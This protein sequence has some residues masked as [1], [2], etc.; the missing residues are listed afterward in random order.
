MRSTGLADVGVP[1]GRKL[2]SSVCITPLFQSHKNHLGYSAMLSKLSYQSMS[3]IL[4]GLVCISVDLAASESDTITYE[5][6]FFAPYNPVTAL[7]IVDRVPGFKLKRQG[8]SG[9]GGEE[10]V[11]GFGNNLSDVLINGKRP[12]TKSTP[13]EKILARY[14]AE[15]V[16]KVDLIRGATGSLESSKASVVVNLTMDMQQGKGSIP[17]QA[18]LSIEEGNI[19]PNGNA[20]YVGSRN[21][22]NYSIGIEREKYRFEFG[23]PE[24]LNSLIGPDEYRDE[25]LYEIPDKW[26][27]SADMERQI[28]SRDSFR[29]NTQVTDNNYEQG[30]DS[31]R[32]PEGQSRADLEKQRTLNDS[33]EVELGGDYERKFSDTLRMKVIGLLNRKEADFGSTLTA[34]PDAGTDSLSD[35]S[36]ESEEGESIV[37]FEVKWS[38]W[39][40]HNLQYGLEVTENFLDSQSTFIY[41]DGTGP[42][43][44]P[45]PGGN[46][47]VE[48]F[49]AEVFISDSWTVSKKLTLD[50]GLAFEYS[51]IKQTGDTDLS[52][53]F[54]YPK[55]FV[56]ATY[57]PS[58][59][60]QWRFRLQ[61]EVGQ[62][63]FFEFVSSANLE[64]D[65]LN[66]GN[67]NLKPE[68]SWVLEFGFE[69]R[70][71]E[72][73][74]I[75]FMPFYHAI[76][77][78]EDLVPLGDTYEAPGNIG[79]GERWG[80]EA[81]LTTALDAVGIKN[82]R[83]DISYNW[84]D[85]SVEDPVTGEDRQLSGEA[86]WDVD[87]S[88]R[89]DLASRRLSYGIG[90]VESDVTTRYGLDE[91]T[92]GIYVPGM[93]FFI[94]K[95]FANDYKLRLDAM[96]VLNQGAHRERRVYDMSRASGIILFTEKRVR[97]DDTYF[98][99][100]LSGTFQH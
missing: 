16:I 7:D 54:T 71:G 31:A 27:F 95:S 49:R 60:T 65:D 74:V 69:R 34:L 78:V 63:D 10:K 42:A 64:D 50:T 20:T 19:T 11:R 13:I 96:N 51:K 14:P 32:Y 85:S 45:L 23:G 70:F 87:I 93:T 79:N 8:P 25:D 26:T 92:T 59:F 44:I 76:D 18:S 43:L 80:F 84:Q 53:K 21:N 24:I 5:P 48:E 67:P 9:S 4:L 47:R 62:L 28:G 33:L 99:L 15:S 55:P 86:V 98:G 39:Q 97:D 52:R 35:F 94:E 41:D 91:I 22:T 30:E 73:G 29:F 58:E 89:Q 75:E 37:R 38:G 66:L 81:A 3:L 68:Q 17:W 72:I 90:Y 40:S 82:G 61:R 2:I 1:Q 6:S 83:L 56:T 77:D 46:A 100:S 57:S 12:S 88:L 36:Y